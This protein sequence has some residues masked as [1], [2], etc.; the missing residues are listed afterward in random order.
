MFQAD[1]SE[2]KAISQ[3]SGAQHSVLPTHGAGTRGEQEVNILYRITCTLVGVF[4][5][6]PDLHI[7]PISLLIQGEWC[8]IAVSLACPHCKE[9]WIYVFPEMELRGLNPMCL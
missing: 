3:R 6:S 2:S 7:W 8:I 1:V 5:L 9:I 4:L